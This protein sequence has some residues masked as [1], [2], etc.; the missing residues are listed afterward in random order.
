MKFKYILFLLFLIFIRQASAKQYILLDRD[1]HTA[2]GNGHVSFVWDSDTKALSY[3]TDI[4]Q[5]AYHGSTESAEYFFAAIMAE[6]CSSDLGGSPFPPEVKVC[7]GMMAYNNFLGGIPKGD[8]VFSSTVGNIGSV[9]INDVLGK[10]PN[11]AQHFTA[12]QIIPK[13]L[14]K[15]HIC[16]QTWS[17]PSFMP[18]FTGVCE[19]GEVAP[20]EPVPE[21]TNCNLNVSTSNIDYGTLNQN[22]VN[23]SRKIV[24][25]TIICSAESD[26]S[27]SFDKGKINS[28]N[29]E[30][31]IDLNG[32]L[33]AHLE[34]SNKLQAG[35]NIPVSGKL[36]STLVTSSQTVTVGK[37]SNSAILKAEWP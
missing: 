5:W 11:R 31:D 1:F 8:A 18:T 9:I 21:E 33:T 3:T 2:D 27:F 12:T 15:I 20:V 28:G 37:H 36:Y 32:G 6:N 29:A 25:Y 4:P 26:L 23:G 16:F 34:T 10:I 19:T 13:G 22:E 24:G 14:K 35:E 17:D 7:G 30:V